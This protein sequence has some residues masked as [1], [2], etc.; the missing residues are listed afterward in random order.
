MEESFDTTLENC[1]NCGASLKPDDRFCPSCGQK[2][3]PL[4]Q[5]LSKVVYTFLGS[6]FQLDSRIW[7]TFLQL[8]KPGELTIEY[9][10]GR[11]KRYINPFRVFFFF[12]VICFA[13]LAYNT[14]SIK[15]EIGTNFLKSFEFNDR[16]MEALQEF[17]TAAD[18]SPVLINAPDVKQELDSIVNRLISKYDRNDSITLVHLD[19][20]NPYK[21]SMRDL[22][23]LTEDE[24]FERYKIEGF[25]DKIFF[26][27]GIRL[28]KSGDSFLQFFIRQSSWAALFLMPFA[29]LL[30]KMLY[31]RRNRYFEEHFIFALHTHSMIFF[32]VIISL[33]A[34]YL[35][36]DTLLGIFT[37][38]LTAGA[39][40]Y[41]F[42]AMYRY[43]QQ[44]FLKTLLKYSIFLY[45]YAVIFVLILVMTI[46]ASVLLF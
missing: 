9:F 37:L 27:Q 3:V 11:R 10:R 44:S 16:K 31:I 4:R 15:F 45:F 29:A 34:T 2:I 39:L 20:R 33:L 25:W 5:P 23:N 12:L 14:A 18:T 6:I 19:H 24:L 36:S 26:R 17:Q 32:I 42:V 8:F 35:R 38:V 43:Y 40:L 1:T 22:N 30:L 21:L 46:I 41:G 13:L 28:M 7:Q